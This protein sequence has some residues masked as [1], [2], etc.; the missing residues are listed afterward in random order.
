[1]NTQGGIPH[2]GRFALGTQHI[3][4]GFRYLWQFPRLIPYALLPMILQLVVLVSL[5]ALFG[6]QF[7]DLFHWLSGWVQVWHVDNPDGIWMKTLNF[8]LCG[9]TELLRI[10]VFVV[11]LIF[12]SIAGFLI[13][14]IL[15]SPLNDLLSEKTEATVRTPQSEPFTLRYLWRLIRGEVLKAIFLILIPLVLLV[16]NLVPVIGTVAYVILSA[17]FG[18]WAM[19][20]AYVD[21]PLSRATPGFGPRL[22]FYR[23]NFS[24]LCGFGVIFFIPFF[25]FI[26]SSP[27]VVGST[28]LYLRLSDA[29]T[30]DTG[31][32]APL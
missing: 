20:I 27:L 26:F 32:R 23:H 5:L 28:L 24:A 8:F 7:S 6:S 31:S 22:A 21:Y 15:T 25:N 30:S 18:M 9:A 19:G 17:L 3:G 11:G 4:L 1:M 10:L 14:M 29:D 12:V 2:V 13:G 16:L